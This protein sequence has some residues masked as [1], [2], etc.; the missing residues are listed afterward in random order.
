MSGWIDCAK[1]QNDGS[2]GLIIIRRY[3]NGVAS[4]DAPSFENK[5]LR[6]VF[7]MRLVKVKRKQEERTV[8]NLKMVFTLL[9]VCEM[10]KEEK[11]TTLDVYQIYNVT[12]IWDMQEPEQM[13]EE[14]S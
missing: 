8:G 1:A 7:K 12:E 6:R 14:Q 9:N 3:Q 13:L 4:S 11:D 5:R 10:T 2:Q